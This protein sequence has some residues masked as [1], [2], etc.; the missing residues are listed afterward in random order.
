[1]NFTN[2]YYKEQNE[3][4]PVNEL[5]GKVLTHAVLNKLLDES[6]GTALKTAVMYIFNDFKKNPEKYKSVDTFIQHIKD[7]LEDKTGL[8]PEKLDKLKT[9]Y[10]NLKGAKE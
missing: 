10:N 5:W 7:K 9:L 3:G 1:M 4:K 8:T 2:H 6:W